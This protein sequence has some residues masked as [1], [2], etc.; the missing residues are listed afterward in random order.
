MA[1]KCPLNALKITCS[2]VCAWYDP[3]QEACCII[4]LLQARTVIP[5]PIIIEAASN[6]PR[7]TFVSS[8]H[9]SK[10][11]TKPKWSQSELDKLKELWGTM[12][13]KK[14]AALMRPKTLHQIVGKARILGLGKGITG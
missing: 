6:E 13:N 9:K 8:Y 14:V 1:K 11:K 5:E 7:E 4:D 3:S 2:P 10:V 12:P